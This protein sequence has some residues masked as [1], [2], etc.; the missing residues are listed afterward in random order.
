MHS[1]TAV[2]L[3]VTFGF[4]VGPSWRVGNPVKVVQ[5][6]ERVYRGPAANVSEHLSFNNNETRDTLITIE[7]HAHHN[8]KFDY[9]TDQS[10]V[11]L[12]PSVSLAY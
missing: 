3:I 11:C 2:L 7:A 4:D 1:S 12:E 10:M 8:T 6:R 9:S 5:T